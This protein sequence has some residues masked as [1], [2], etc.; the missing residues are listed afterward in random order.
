MKKPRIPLMWIFSYLLVLLLPLFFSS[1]VYINALSMINENIKKSNMVA[2]TQTQSGMDQMFTDIAFQWQKILVSDPV[3]SVLYAAPPLN[4]IKQMAVGQLQN[5]LQKDSAYSAYVSDIYVYFKAS[6]MVVTTTGCYGSAYFSS[7]LESKY[8]FSLDDFKSSFGQ[9][10]PMVVRMLSNPNDAQQQADKIAVILSDVTV[11]DTPD[12]ICLF[13]LDAKTIRSMLEKY[14]EGYA[15]DEQMVWAM[16]NGG[17]YISHIEDGAS[18]FNLYNTYGA[19]PSE[20]DFYDLMGK[21]A[22]VAQTTS[23]V[24]GWTLVSA[25][26]LESYAS[27]LSEIKTV[28]LA[29]L[30]FCIFAGSVVS[31]VFAKKNYRPVERIAKMFITQLQS[32]P[33]GAKYDSDFAVMEQGVLTLLQE[34]KNYQK[35]IDQ[36][37]N[38][39]KNMNLVKILR[40]KIHSKESFQS[41]CADFEI[42][43]PYDRFL[44]IGIW[45]TDCSNAFFEENT[46]EDEETERL[47]QVIISSV[48][49]ELINEKYCGNICEYDD[50]MFCLV[51]FKKQVLPAEYNEIY[52]DITAI[53]QKAQD[54]I[55]KR[56]G[57]GQTYYISDIEEEFC[58]INKAY[59]QVQL[60]LQQAEDFAIQKPVITSADISAQFG[61][62][63][64]NPAVHIQEQRKHLLGAIMEEDYD[65]ADSLYVEVINNSMASLPK[66]ATTC[67]FITYSL[68][69]NLLEQCFIPGGGVEITKEYIDCMKGCRNFEEMR[70]MMRDLYKCINQRVCAE[71]DNSAC[72]VQTEEIIDYINEN[73]CNP[74]ITVSMIAEHFAVSQSYLLRMFKKHSK[75]GVL[76]YIHQKR[77]D[78]AKLL[79]K[80]SADTINAIAEKVGYTNSLALIR[81]FKRLEGVTPTSY[82]TIAGGRQ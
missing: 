75:G 18:V 11:N 73:Y 49:G 33:K 5:Q 48:I 16:Q 40:G 20:K 59:L 34:K 69:E 58:G 51:G 1:V 46:V 38:I 14:S 36:Q 52:S 21:K 63:E 15:S 9:P 41:A 61:E 66:S 53:C 39:I 56:F 43:Y 82:R 17:T 79:L 8:Y 45:I 7:K 74:N 37:K 47:I 70:R 50:R 62:Q 72:A 64:N 42:N 35:T 22:A 13:I 19:N 30:V 6:D 4:A 10:S 65:L 67:K 12:A 60:G 25:I 3:R 29:Y 77:V 68:I 44:V 57:I 31:F 76:D 32:G 27:Q 23:S 2:L 78:E 26:S 28:Y 81:A 71:K 24:T 80:N 54:F 55:L